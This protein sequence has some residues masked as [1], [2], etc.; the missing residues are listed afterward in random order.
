MVKLYELR[1]G[2]FFYVPLP[3]TQ[4]KTIKQ[5]KEIRQKH[6]LLDG[7]WYHLNE[8][9]PIPLT[10]EIL[11]KCGF[12]RFEWIKESNVFQGTYFNCKVDENGVQ[13]FGVDL[14]NVKPVKYLHE[15]QN[16][17]SQLT[18]TELEVHFIQADFAEKE[19]EVIT[20]PDFVVLSSNA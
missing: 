16:L 17:F 11:L 12:T 20:K 18:E 1:I 8:L 5:A 19:A 7:V 10:E 3:S 14:N 13:P 4:R 15:F 9:I 2:N 6:V